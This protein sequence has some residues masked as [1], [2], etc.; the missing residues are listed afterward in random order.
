MILIRHQRF[1]ED[2]LDSDKYATRDTA[3]PM[4]G[5]LWNPDPFLHC[6]LGTALLRARSF[7]HLQVFALKAWGLSSSWAPATQPA[8]AA[9]GRRRR[10]SLQTRRDSKF[11]P[12]SK[13]PAWHN[14]LI[15]VSRGR[16]PVAC[17]SQPAARGLRPSARVPASRSLR[18]A[19]C[20]AVC[21]RGLRALGN[22]RALGFAGFRASSQFFGS[23][24]LECWNFRVL[25][26]LRFWG[27]RVLRL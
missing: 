1:G 15:L 10:S 5:F 7:Q 16:R 20:G 4:N 19:A 17:V 12:S 26:L 14:R 21:G 13:S 22:F 6:V 2:S 9:L 23:R 18:P 8:V 3:S 27:F 11:S 25:G 24:V